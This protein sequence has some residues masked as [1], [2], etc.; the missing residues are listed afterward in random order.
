MNSLCK[1]AG[2]SALALGLAACGATDDTQNAAVP[3]NYH[4]ITTNLQGTVFNAVTGARVDADV[5]LV[6]GS[7]YRNAK[8]N[9]AYP[10][11]YFFADIPTSTNGNV[12]FR[13]EASADGFQPV[14]STV[15]FN[16]NTANLQDREVWSLGNFYLYP[17]GSTAPDMTVTV[18]Y[19]GERIEGATVM[20]QPN[21]ASNVLTAD[22]TAIIAPTDGFQGALSATSDADGNAVFD[23]DTLVLGGR[24]AV[25]V[26]PMVYEDTQLALATP[27]SVTVGTSAI[28]QTVALADIVPGTTDGLYVV[29]ASNED[30]NAINSNGTLIIHLSRPVSIVN[31]SLASAS[32]TNDTTAALDTNSQGSDVTATVSTDGLTLTLSPNFSTNPQAFNGSNS[33]TADNGLTITYSD[34][35][36]RLTDSDDTTLIEVFDS[37]NGLVNSDGNVVDDTVQITLEF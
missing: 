28:I 32:L 21:T 2:L 10:G 34:L 25:Q 35:F 18:T 7:D 6:Q 4:D 5:L 12:T 22:A 3:Q 13:M 29:S 31:E 14:V 11:D 23:G 30:S 19:N 27:T 9:S 33:G 16:V 36:V 24:Y 37:V 15:T 20:L 8:Q 26:L 17:L 1:A